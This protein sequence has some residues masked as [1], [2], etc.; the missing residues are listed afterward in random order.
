ML[1]GAD[2]VAEMERRHLAGVSGEMM[3]G[4]ESVPTSDVGK[5]RSERVLRAVEQVPPR[6]TAPRPAPPRCRAALNDANALA[7]FLPARLRCC[8][9]Q[10]RRSPTTPSKSLL[11]TVP[12]RSPPQALRCGL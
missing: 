5:K 2:S 8:K 6:P 1:A 9:R 12:V 4:L 10:R 7:Q 3:S 11:R